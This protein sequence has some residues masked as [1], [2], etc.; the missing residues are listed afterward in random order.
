MKYIISVSKAYKHRG[1]HKHYS[2]KKHWFVYYYNECGRLGIKQINL[3]QALY[4]KTKKLHRVKRYCI[5][6]GRVGIFLVKSKK[7]KIICTDCI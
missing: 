5:E 4:F 3:L 6:C 7:Q 2:A 1:N